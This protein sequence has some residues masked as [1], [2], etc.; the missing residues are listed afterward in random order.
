MTDEAMQAPAT[1]DDLRV[2]QE[3]RGTIT[4]LGVY[5]AMVDLGLD[6]DALL[7]VSQLGRNDFRNI[8]EVYDVGTEIVAYVL[9]VDD[10]NR[11][12]LTLEKPPALPWSEIRKGKQYK[13]TVTRLEAYGAFVDIGAERPGMVHVSELTDGFV[14]SPGDVVQVGDEVEVRVIKLNRRN[15]QIDLSMKTPEED[16]AQAMEPVDEVPSAM[17]LAFR[18]AEKRQEERRSKKKNRKRQFSQD[19]ILDRTLRDHNS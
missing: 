10:N 6:N 18:R 8:E 16:L 15:R 3:V 4:Y 9:K 7:H 12:A 2:G 5:G 1:M 14:E 11:V 13:G 17:E 19:D